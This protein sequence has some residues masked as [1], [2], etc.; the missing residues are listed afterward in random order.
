MYRKLLSGIVV[1]ALLATAPQAVFGQDILLGPEVAWNDDFD[2]GIGA[3]VEFGLNNVTPGLGLYGDFIYFFGDDVDLGTAGSVSQTYFE[4]NANAV[5]EFP[6]KESTITPFALAG[7]NFGNRDVDVEGE[8]ED[9]DPD[10][11]GFKV[12][13]NLGGGIQFNLGDFRPRAGA[14]FVLGGYET[15]TVFGFLPFQI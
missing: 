6:L 5:Y 13:V 10:G 2:F 15:F 7:A 3:G 12:G 11:D 9:Y 14:R 1:A 8:F 4:F